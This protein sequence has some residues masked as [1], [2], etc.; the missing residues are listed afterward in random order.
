MTSTIDRHQAR[1]AKTRRLILLFVAWPASVAVI[2]VG[3][4]IYKFHS[5]PL[6]SE[7]GD[8]GTF[9]DFLGGIVNPVAG[10][11]TIV[12]LVLT[13]RSQQDELEEQ[14]RQLAKQSFDQSFF[15]WTSSYRELI[16]EL[17]LG[18]GSDSDPRLMGVVALDAMT[19]SELISTNLE[20]S[21]LLKE[22]ERSD[23]QVRERLCARKK[24]LVH[25]WWERQFAA[26]EPQLGALI[27]TLYSLLR[28]VDSNPHVSWL[29]KWDAVSILRA[30]LSGPELRMIFFNGFLPEGQK[31]NEYVRRYALFDNLRLNGHNF[32]ILAYRLNF[33]PF[34]PES[35]NS[36]L[37]R[38]SLLEASDV[39]PIS[40]SNQPPSNV[41]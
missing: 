34:E 11:V 40:A 33:H 3:L 9:G 8:W 23:A 20:T 31:F 12:L 36:D 38:Q 19:R 26:N 24:N 39:T 6:S 7:T 4:F 37:A 5:N 2:A 27:R 10:L 13:L 41:R 32:V 18:D 16:T 35:F 17:Q 21:L 22:Y 1:A 14:R 28:W 30:R 29:E 25:A 15:G